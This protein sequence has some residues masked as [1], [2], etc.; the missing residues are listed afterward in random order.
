MRIG[1]MV[2]QLLEE[3]KAAPVDEPGRKRLA[4]VLHTSIKRAQGRA[5]A[6]A[7]R[8]A[9]PADRALRRGDAHRV[10]AADRPGPAGRL[11]RGA[12]PRHPDRDL[13]PADGRALP[14]GADA[15][16]AAARC[17]ARHARRSSRATTRIPASPA[18]R[19]GCTSS[20]LGEPAAQLDRRTVVVDRLGGGVGGVVDLL[21][22]LA[23]R[24]AAAGP[25]QH[26][27]VVAAVA[28]GE[29]VLAG[30]RRARSATYSRP[31]ALE[32]PTGARSSQ[33][34][35]PTT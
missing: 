4:K 21:H 28:D 20:P 10:G 29:D 15:P 34:V 25:P 9:R 14:A 33:A 12:L 2:Q 30:R 16:R 18:R 35:Q 24:H 11:A 19:A 7:R 26:L 31:E 13:R 5:G 6:R 22:G 8:R 27:D 3:V 17:D 23:H 1:R 32:T